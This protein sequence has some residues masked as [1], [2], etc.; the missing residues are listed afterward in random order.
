MAKAGDCSVCDWQTAMNQEVDQTRTKAYWASVTGTSKDAIRRHFIHL[1]E[2]AGLPD[3]VVPAAPTARK[4]LAFDLETSPNLAYVWGLWNQNVAISQLEEATEVICFGARWLDSNETIFRSVHHHG[5]EKMLQDLWDLFNEADAVM[6]WNS[7]SFDSKHVKREFLEAGMTPPAPW[8]ELDLMRVVK[9]EF[10][11]P[12]NKLD[13]VAQKLNVGSKTSHTGFQLWK[14]C[15]A[16]DNKAWALMQKYQIQDV[17]LLIDLHEALLP[18]IKNYPRLVDSD[19]HMCPNCHNTK[20]K[21]DGSIRTNTRNYARYLCDPKSGGC[22]KWLR[23][24]T[25]TLGATILPA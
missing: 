10:R 14:D 16:G 24:N 17:D 20:L 6:G 18:W 7:A 19:A 11:F 4:I 25:S 9:K 5:K 8:K 22:G 13:Y 12:S 3:A 21:A 23:S 15:M 2:T 1:G